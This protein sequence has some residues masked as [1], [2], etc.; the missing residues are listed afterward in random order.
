MFQK[1]NKAELEVLSAAL[2]LFSVATQ[3]AR[4]KKTLLTDLFECINFPKAFTAA[5]I[6]GPD[7]ALALSQLLLRLEEAVSEQL[8]ALI[9]SSDET[10]ELDDHLGE[11]ED[12]FTKLEAAGVE[13]LIRVVRGEGDSGYADDLEVMPPDLSLDQM[14]LRRVRSLTDDYAHDYSPDGEGGG[15]DIAL[16]PANRTITVRIFDNL[17]EEVDRELSTFRLPANVITK[18]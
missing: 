8:K 15:V 16:F 6:E 14:L 17:V 9:A 4:P 5:G 13:S 12:V 7:E 18:L 11:W 10:T 2:S 3:S 1:F